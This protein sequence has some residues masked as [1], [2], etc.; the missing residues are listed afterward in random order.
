MV[1]SCAKYLS[2][3]GLLIDAE[4]HVKESTICYI[5]KFIYKDNLLKLLVKVYY[6]Y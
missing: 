6:D 5:N 1:Q 3:V 2:H 4:H